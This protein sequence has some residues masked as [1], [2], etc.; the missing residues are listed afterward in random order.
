ME[1]DI[2]LSGYDSIFATRL[3]ELMNEKKDGK[4]VTQ[5]AIAD[6]IGGSRQVISQYMNGVV[7]PQIDKLEKIADFFEVSCD[8]LL[9]RTNIRTTDTTVQAICQ[10][11]GLSEKSVNQLM[12]LNSQ[13]LEI[14]GG[15][16]K[17]D[18]KLSMLD[19]LLSDA[20]F[21]EGQKNF[22]D[23]LEIAA[24]YHELLV[25]T[26]LN[27]ER[28]IKVSNR[29]ELDHEDEKG[30]DFEVDYKNNEIKVVLTPDIVIKAFEKELLDTFADVINSVLTRQWFLYKKNIPQSKKIK[31][32]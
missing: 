24:K 3:R 21:N 11:I 30:N 26:Q 25:Y 1:N 32:N 23:V 31:N 12:Q 9:G 5:Q 15:K 14:Y 4:K 7:T 13:V 20:N 2:T 17:G 19:H 6:V 28:N 8:Y 22:Y 16:I 18:F 10:A 27:K 29:F